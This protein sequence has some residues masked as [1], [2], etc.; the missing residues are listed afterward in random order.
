MI[1][2]LS[3]STFAAVTFTRVN[4]TP[5]GDLR[6]QVNFHGWFHA[7]FARETLEGLSDGPGWISRISGS[8]EKA[9]KFKFDFALKKRIQTFTQIIWCVSKRFQKVSLKTVLIIVQNPAI[10]INQ[11]MLFFWYSCGVVGKKGATIRPLFLMINKIFCQL[12][13]RDL[14]SYRGQQKTLAYYHVKCHGRVIALFFFAYTWI[15]NTRNLP[16]ESLF[17]HTY[18]ISRSK[19][20]IYHEKSVP[21]NRT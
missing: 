9:S 14:L 15:L 19:R 1:R 10:T 6:L 3:C 16:R 21:Y 11:N 13:L 20:V 17:T 4:P 8:I 2:G 18:A 7:I 12:E 5:Q